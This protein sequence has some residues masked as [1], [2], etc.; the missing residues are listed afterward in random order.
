VVAE[1]EEEELQIQSPIPTKT[2]HICSCALRHANCGGTSRPLRLKHAAAR[3]TEAA[4]LD[5][6]ASR[7]TLTHRIR[8]TDDHG[9]GHCPRGD[10]SARLAPWHHATQTTAARQGQ[11]AESLDIET[12]GA[13]TSGSSE[14]GAM[15]QEAESLVSG[16]SAPPELQKLT[17]FV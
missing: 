15:A 1:E 5:H 17:P 16:A 4:L 14:G 3:Q 8:Q 6:D 7:W 11:R 13:T 2:P 10:D 12:A 9:L